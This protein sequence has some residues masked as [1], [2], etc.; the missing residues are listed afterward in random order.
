MSRLLTTLSLLAVLFASCV[1]RPAAR[2]PRAVKMQ[3]DLNRYVASKSARIGVAVIINGV[4]TVAVNGHD[5]FPM[6]SVY[7]FPQAIAVAEL[8]ERRRMNMNGFISVYESDMLP[9]T[10]SP[11]RDELGQVHM[12][13]P[14]SEVLRYSVTLSDNNACDRL[15]RFI[16]GVAAADSLMKAMGFD[17]INIVATEQQMHSDL[18]LCYDNSSSPLQ[19]AALL[20]TFSRSLRHQSYRYDIIHDLMT[21]CTTGTDRLLFPLLRRDALLGHKTGTGDV[22]SRGLIIGLNDVGYVKLPDGNTYSIA[23]FVA[24]SPYDMKETSAIISDI[25][26]IVASCFD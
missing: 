19:M 9:D 26:E 25:S 6:L 3:A 24:D 1:T 11:M 22:N 10:Y 4:D 8:C 23:V 15:F 14:L 16:G 21:S 12:R 5:P 18:S 7:K 20:D 17:E 13:L 2:D